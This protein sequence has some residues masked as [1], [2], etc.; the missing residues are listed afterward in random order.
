VLCVETGT[1]YP[2]ISAA[3]RAVYVTPK[4][5]YDA[6]DHPT[7]TSASYTWRTPTKRM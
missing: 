7:K 2:S 4:C 5:I 1:T 3:A 6:L